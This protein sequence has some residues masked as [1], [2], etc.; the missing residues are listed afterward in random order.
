MHGFAHSVVAS[1]GERKVGDAAAC[2]CQRQVL[3]NPLD[4]AYEIDGVGSVFLDACGYGE[5]IYVEYYVLWWETDFSEQTVCSLAN[6][7]LTFKGG[8]LSFFVEGHNYYCSS[9]LE[10]E[11][12]LFKEVRFASL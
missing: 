10:Q 1:E 8:C 12:G 2:L 7:S 4:S 11:S 9:N 5:Y 6:G 3:L